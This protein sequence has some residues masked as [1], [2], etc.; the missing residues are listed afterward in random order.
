[1]KPLLLLAA[2]LFSFWNS[3]TTVSA[4]SS[5]SK[6]RKAD[7]LRINISGVPSNDQ[8]SMANQSFIVSNDGTVSVTHLANEIRA[9]GLTPSQLARELER[10][11]RAAGIYTKP[12]ISI[13][14]V[15]GPDT[16]LVVTVNG[17]VRK[18]GVCVFRPGMKINE[19]I[20]ECGSFDEFAK[21]GK[22]RLMR[23]GQTKEIDMRNIS[24]H[25]ERNITLEAGDE[26]IVPGAGYK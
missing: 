6:L 12:T 1:M 4:Q 24:S 20:A 2:F 14:R 16:Q 18:S 10:A 9:E 8:A 15:V 22:V 17:S 23:K 11:Y 3:A 13:Q 26:I 25:Q 21:P 5:E 19:A 7:A